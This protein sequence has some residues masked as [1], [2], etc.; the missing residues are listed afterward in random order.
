MNFDRTFCTGL[1]CD[2]KENCDRWTEHLKRWLDKNPSFLKRHFSIAQF[3]DHMGDCQMFSPIEKTE[4]QC[5]KS[6]VQTASN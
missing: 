4:D 1:R 6:D 2:K 3:A 5:F